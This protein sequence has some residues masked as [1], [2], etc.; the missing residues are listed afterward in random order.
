[1]SVDL[2]GHGCTTGISASD[3]AK[4]IQALI[5]PLTQPEELGRPGHIFPCGPKQVACCAAQDTPKLRWI[6]RV[7][8]DLSQ[9]ASSWKS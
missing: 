3:R 4:T 8:L 9:P 5:N 1:M 6:S 2:I 7:L